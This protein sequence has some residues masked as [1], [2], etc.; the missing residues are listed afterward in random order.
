MW[1]L[2]TWHF[3][4]RGRQEHHQTKF[5]DFTLQRDYDGNEFLT[6]AEGP[7]K[8]RQGGLSVKI[9]LVTAKLFAT[10]NEEGCPSCLNDTWRSEMQKNGP[11]RRKASFEHLVQENPNG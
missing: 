4:L 9:R 6:F 2:L 10:E 1:W 5:E 11:F 3:G 8:M 7:T